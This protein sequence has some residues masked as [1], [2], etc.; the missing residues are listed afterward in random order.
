M[1][2]VFTD[3]A[4]IDLIRIG[5]LIARDSPRR[6]LSFVE[7]LEAHCLRIPGMALAYPLLP[8]HEHAG[9]RRVVHGNYLI[10]YRI[11]GDAV[12]ILHI[13]HGAQDYDEILF[14]RE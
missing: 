2:L 4:R 3:E 6:A 8:R 11:A 10:F 13:L 5:D 7:E 1:R 14:R 12:E 9:F